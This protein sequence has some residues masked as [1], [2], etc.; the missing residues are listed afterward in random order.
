[1]AAKD[2]ILVSRWAFSRALAAQI[3]AGAERYQYDDS[4]ISAPSVCGRLCQLMSLFAS[5]FDSGS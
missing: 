2:G 3:G 5:R 1:M 4:L